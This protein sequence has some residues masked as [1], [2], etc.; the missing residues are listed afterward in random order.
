MKQLTLIDL[1]QQLNE[2]S[3]ELDNN[4]Q[5]LRNAPNLAIEIKGFIE[6]YDLYDGDLQKLR[7]QIE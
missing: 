1:I 4:I 6:F 2:G 7:T 5:T 3:S